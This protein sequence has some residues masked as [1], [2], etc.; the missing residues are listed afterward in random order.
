[1]HGAEGSERGSERGVVRISRLRLRCSL[2]SLSPF[3]TKLARHVL[4]EGHT[5]TFVDICDG[6]PPAGV[7][8]VVSNMV[9]QDPAWRDAFAAADAVVH[10]ACDNPF[11]EATWQEAANSMDITFNAMSVAVEVGVPRFVFASSN[12]V[13]GGHKDVAPN[14]QE[15]L[16]PATEPLTGTK[17]L[18]GGCEWEGVIRAAC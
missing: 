11:P 16:T 2:S 4:D 3:S 14:R 1:M 8:L 12:H 5:C 10:L 6:R 18:A 15:A 9:Q 17:W 13:M 7:D